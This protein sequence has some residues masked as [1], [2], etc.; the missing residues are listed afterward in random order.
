VNPIDVLDV[1]SGTGFAA[2][3][4]ATLGHRVTGIDLAPNMLSIARQLAVQRNLT[5]K[6]IEADGVQPPFDGQSFDAVVSRHSLWT[7]R[8]AGRALRNWHKLLRSSGRVLL[9]DALQNGDPVVQAL[10][11]AGFRNVT[12]ELL[13]DGLCETPGQREYALTADR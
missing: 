13:P 7:L 9:I 10:I 2:L 6:F 1:C 12:F 11:S 3:I 5:A 4:C 8:E